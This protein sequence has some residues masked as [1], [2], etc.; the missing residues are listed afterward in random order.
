[1]RH[2]LIFLIL[3]LVACCSEVNTEK[4]SNKSDFINSSTQIDSNSTK[5]DTLEIH[6]KPLNTVILNGTIWIRHVATDCID[7]LMFS[8]NV[9]GREFRCEMQID[10]RFIYRVLDDTLF[11]NEYGLISEVDGLKGEEIKH[12]WRYVLDSRGLLMLNGYPERRLIY[13]LVEN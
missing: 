9:E 3:V 8:T 12:R 6:I 5:N 7:S 11:M 4:Q 13:K 1:M 2:N 10:N